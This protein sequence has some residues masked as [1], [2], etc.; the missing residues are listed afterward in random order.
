MVLAV[1]NENITSN[2]DEH[3]GTD[4]IYHHGHPGQT[5]YL[6]KVKKK[7]STIGSIST[8]SYQVYACNCQ[9]D[10]YMWILLKGYNDVLVMKYKKKIIRR[11]YLCWIC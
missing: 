5:S 6:G 2:L 1:F 3:L 11:L 9:L 8:K 7:V 10:Q 4:N